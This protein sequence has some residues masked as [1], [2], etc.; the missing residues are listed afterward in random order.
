MVIDSIMTTVWMVVT[1]AVPKYLGRFWPMR[2][3][4]LRQEIGEVSLG[5]ETDTETLHPFDLSILLGLGF[6]RSGSRP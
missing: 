6:G 1:L 5:I 3:G 2:K 4:A